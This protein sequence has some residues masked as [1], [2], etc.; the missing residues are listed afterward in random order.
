MENM[1]YSNSESQELPTEDISATVGERLTEFLESIKKSWNSSCKNPYIRCQRT[2]EIQ[3]FR[4]QNDSE[5]IDSYR[6]DKSTSF[7][8]CA[9]GIAA[10][11]AIAMAALLSGM[12]RKNMPCSKE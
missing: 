10:V 6:C 2:H 11:S 8:L 4:T 1:P 12:K 3:V 7:S 9:F 5:P